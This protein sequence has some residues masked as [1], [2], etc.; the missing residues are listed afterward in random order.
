MNRSRKARHARR[1][2]LIA[3]SAA[4]R[5]E[6]ESCLTAWKEPLERA[7]RALNLFR[8]LRSQDWLGRAQTLVRSGRA[9]IDTV[10]AAR[11]SGPR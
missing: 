9:L 11:R 4:Y 6:I 2:E 3:R 8:T 1:Q 7:E 5:D 10:S